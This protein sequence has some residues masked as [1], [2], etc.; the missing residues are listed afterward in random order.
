MHLKKG[1]QGVH[2]AQ[3]LPYGALYTV[4]VKIVSMIGL[5]H[6]IRYL[7]TKEEKVRNISRHCS[8]IKMADC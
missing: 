8:K 1:M 5:K 7:E 3:Y 4:L 6:N 2:V